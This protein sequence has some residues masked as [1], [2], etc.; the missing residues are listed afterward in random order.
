LEKF[1]KALILIVTYFLE[2]DWSVGFEVLG[3]DRGE[4]FNR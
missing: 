3:K 2:I 4:G 1:V